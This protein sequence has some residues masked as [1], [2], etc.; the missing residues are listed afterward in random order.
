[1]HCDIIYI[2]NEVAFHVHSP[3]NW[4]LALLL[5]LSPALKLSGEKFFE[6]IC[7]PIRFSP[8]VTVVTS[9]VPSI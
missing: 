7:L 3:H 1:M 9:T 6:S 4:Y 8:V 5:F 2:T